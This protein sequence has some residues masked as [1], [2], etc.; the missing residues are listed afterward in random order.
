MESSG[1]TQ[2]WLGVITFM[3]A[4]IAL[5]NISDSRRWFYWQVWQT[6]GLLI[7]TFVSIVL[8]LWFEERAD[9]AFVDFSLFKN[10]TYTG[11][12]FLIS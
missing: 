1:K 2:I 5:Q 12:S 9:K 11:K 4:M 10:A 8:F 3:I 7:I 6:I